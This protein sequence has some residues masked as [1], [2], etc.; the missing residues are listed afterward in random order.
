MASRQKVGP[1][2]RALAEWRRVN[3]A[4]LEKE[5]SRSEKKAA[6]IL[7]GILKGIRIEQR[8]AESEIITVWNHSIDPK[9]TA[10]AKP[11]GI[12]KGTLFVT[13]D[14]SVWLDEIV[15]YRR[16][17]ILQRLQHSFGAEVISKI[18]FRLG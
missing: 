18:S 7:P 11:V 4:P 6:D 12:A 2:E 13:V 10:H 1:R 5:R 15:R 9:I 8:Q 14:S 3:T 16:K 17:E